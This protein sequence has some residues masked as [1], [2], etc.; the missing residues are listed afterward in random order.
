MRYNDRESRLLFRTRLWLYTLRCIEMFRQES[1]GRRVFYDFCGSFRDLCVNMESTT[2]EI[3]VSSSW[4]HGVLSVEETGVFEACAVVNV[5]T[6]GMFLR[7][8]QNGDSVQLL[9]STCRAL[10][11][12]QA[13]VLCGGARARALL[14]SFPFLDTLWCLVL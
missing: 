13:L 14:S 6:S 11:R 4:T 12:W 1:V 5:K 3:H 10:E 7:I 9:S 8:T 2:A